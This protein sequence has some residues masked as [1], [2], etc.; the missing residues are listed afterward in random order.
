MKV[1]SFTPIRLLQNPKFCLFGIAVGLTALHLLLTWR[2]LG[3]IDHLTVDVLFWGSLLCLLWRK[4]NI[5]NLESGMLSSF[6]GF[7]LIT[8]V[9]LKSISLFGFESSFLK[10]APLLVALGVCLLASGFKGLKQYW[11]ELLFVLLVCLPE[12][13]LAQTIEEFFKISK[14]TAQFAAFLLWYLGFEVSCQGAN[15]IVTSGYVFVDTSCTGISTALLL[16]KLSVL[17]ILMFSSDWRNKI[18]VFVGAIFIAFVTSG[19]RAALM[20]AVVSNQE[21]FNY[22]HGPEGNQIFSTISILSFGLL[23]RH[24]LQLNKLVSPDNVELQ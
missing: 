12:G 11:Q 21:V 9:L 10:L 20:V 6:I 3:D 19:I 8:L 4:R 22:W 18:S 14:L 1:I 13:L 7:L 16:L 15:V 17:F 24:L 5:L 2:M 23:C